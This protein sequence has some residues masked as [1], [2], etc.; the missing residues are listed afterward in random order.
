MP[1]LA[2]IY[3]ALSRWQGGEYQPKM[4]GEHQHRYVPLYCNQPQNDDVDGELSDFPPI[5]VSTTPR[6]YA[7]RSQAQNSSDGELSD[8]P[9]IRVLDNTPPH[10]YAPRSQAQNSSKGE[11][12]STKVQESTPPCHSPDIPTHSHP[13]RPCRPEANQ[14]KKSFVSGDEGP[15]Q[16]AHFRH[17][18]AGL[19][20][21]NMVNM[22]DG[23]TGLQHAK[24]NTVRGADRRFVLLILI[25]NAR[26]F[27][28]IRPNLH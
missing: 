10:R 18:K 19:G 23:L 11:F 4:K 1:H 26:L 7:P 12:P 25:A 15:L 28:Q 14:S 5:R 24:V 6:R 3:K 16:S 27:F 8:F 20:Q 13:R 9:P 21:S 17:P 22:V 2:D